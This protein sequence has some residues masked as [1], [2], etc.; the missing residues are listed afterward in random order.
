M[1]N[2]ACTAQSAANARSRSLCSD[3]QQVF[4]KKHLLV[5]GPALRSTARLI[6]PLAAVQEGMNSTQIDGKGLAWE[7]SV[8]G[9]CLPLSAQSY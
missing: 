5:G 4:K 1:F 7:F 9:P 8:A 2:W 6:I 3:E